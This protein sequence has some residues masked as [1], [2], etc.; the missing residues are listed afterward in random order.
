MPSAAGTILLDAS[1]NVIIDEAG[2]V[3]VSDGVDDCDCCDECTDCYPNIVIS[4]V[5]ACTTVTP[6]VGFNI[7]VTYSGDINGTYCMTSRTPP[8]GGIATISYGLT[9]PN[10][11]TTHDNF[12]SAERSFDLVV[13]AVLDPETCVWV[14]SIGLNWYYTFGGGHS[15]TIAY[16]TGLTLG[17]T[18]GSNTIAACDAYTGVGNGGTLQVASCCNPYP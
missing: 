8:G 14:A 6:V 9:I 3:M 12:D 10:F 2:N 17:G 18:A 13:G 15:V 11:G 5:T 16:A 4:G 7:T 1:G